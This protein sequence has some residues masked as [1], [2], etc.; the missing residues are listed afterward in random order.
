MSSAIGATNS[1]ERFAPGPAYAQHP[2]KTGLANHHNF[3]DP[4]VANN[5]DLI[6]HVDRDHL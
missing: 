4:D 1:N 3:S 2:S 6:M 5:Y